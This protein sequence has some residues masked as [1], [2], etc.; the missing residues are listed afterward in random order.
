MYQMFL[1]CRVNNKRTKASMKY[2]FRILMITIDDPPPLF[3][4]CQASGHQWV[5]K[6][7]EVKVLWKNWL[8]RMLSEDGYEKSER[9]RMYKH[10]QCMVCRVYQIVLIIQNTVLIVSVVFFCSFL[11]ISTL[12]YHISLW[13]LNILYFV[14]SAPLPNSHPFLS[15]CVSLSQTRIQANCPMHNSCVLVFGKTLL[16][17]QT[18]D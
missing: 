8:R 15:L 11:Y 10:T 12:G 5:Q 13:P 7:Y 9:I 3:C 16:C 1:N 17:W 6:Q 4:R 14:V 2:V 18:V